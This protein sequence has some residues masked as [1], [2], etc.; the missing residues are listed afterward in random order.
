MADLTKAMGLNPSSIYAAFGDKHALFQLAVKRY[1]KQSSAIWR[2]G[3]GR[4]DTRQSD[5]CALRQHSSIF[6][7]FGPSS[8]MYDVSGRDGHKRRRCPGE[9]PYDRDPETKRSRY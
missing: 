2:A 4:T 6:N 9:R 1:L 5:S 7:R 3:A 8:H